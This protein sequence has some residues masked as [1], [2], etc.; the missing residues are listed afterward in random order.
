[1]IAAAVVVATVLTSGYFAVAGLFDSGGTPAH[2]FAR[3]AAARSAVLLGAAA[4]LA[5]TRAWR[6]L[7][8]VLAL[9]GIVQVLDAGVG[10][11]DHNVGK[12]VGPAV[13]AVALFVA[14]RLLGGTGSTARDSKGE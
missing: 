14:V 8:L 2:T 12:A 13:F 3:Y 10:A 1:M 7:R 4:W 5:A 11:A 6:P 9:N